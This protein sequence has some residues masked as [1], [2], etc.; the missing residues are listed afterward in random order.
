M[1]I[2]A[3]SRRPSRYKPWEMPAADLIQ[4]S[5]ALEVWTSLN[6]PEVICARTRSRGLPRSNPFLLPRTFWP[7]LLYQ[8]LQHE[9]ERKQ[10]PLVN[11]LCLL[12][13]LERPALSQS[14]EVGSAMS[15]ALC[16]K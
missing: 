2:R 15:P 13:R 3:S 5:V 9:L 16:L 11:P 6:G 4:T 14:Q 12:N 1:G 8:R 10:P 7:S